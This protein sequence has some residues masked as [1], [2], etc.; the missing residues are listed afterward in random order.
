MPTSTLEERVTVLEVEMSEIK[1]LVAELARAQIRTEQ[2]LQ[3]LSAEMRE[4]KEEMRAFKDEM[5]AF[6]EEMRA[7]KDE[8]REFK[9]EMRAYQER[10]DRERREMNRRWGELANK[11]GTLAEDMVAPNV[12]RILQ[13]LTGCKEEEIE[14]FAVRV[15]KRHARERHRTRE[16]DVVAVCGEYVLINE[17]KST[18]RAE[19]VDAFIRVLQG[20]RDFFPEYGDKKFVGLVSTLYMKPEI[21]RYAERQGLIAMGFGKETFE[22]LNSPDFR[23]RAF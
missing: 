23:P 15:Q 22:V 5:R 20:I 3:R 13:D 6:K 9:E 18:L 16:F 17:T 4:F 21:A 8:M 19:D 7:F 1:Q 10:A 12:P 11:M 2:E 14:F